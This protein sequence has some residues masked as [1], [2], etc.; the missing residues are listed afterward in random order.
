MVATP[1]RAR[2]MPS[3]IQSTAVAVPTVAQLLVNRPCIQKCS[4]QLAPNRIAMLLMM[5]LALSHA[6]GLI[7]P[8]HSVPIPQGKFLSFKD[9]NIV[10]M[11]TSVLVKIDSCSYFMWH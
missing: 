3:A 10:R 2:A 1:A 5:P 11:I 8:S 4:N 7:I 6:L 9:F